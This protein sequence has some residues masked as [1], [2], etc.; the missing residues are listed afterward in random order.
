MASRQSDLD[1]ELYSPFHLR[2]AMEQT[3][4][5]SVLR[6]KNA[7]NSHVDGSSESSNNN[8]LQVTA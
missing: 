5:V 7:C 6:L 8:S 3:G 1:Q 4:E 2:G